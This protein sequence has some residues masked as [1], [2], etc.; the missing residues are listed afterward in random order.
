MRISYRQIFIIALLAAAAVIAGARLAS[1]QAV[2]P[3]ALQ[4]T[5]VD[6]GNVITYRVCFY[7]SATAT[8]PARCT[9]VPVAAAVFQ[10]AG[11]YRIPRS[12]WETGLTPN[13][14]YWPRINA[15]GTSASSGEVAPL[16]SPFSF[17]LDP[18]PRAVTDVILVP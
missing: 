1:A 16:V 5:S 7:P 6:H 3:S 15:V 2:N 4:F 10:S 18:A 12:A 8:T 14:N 17:K 11:V 9:D 13:V